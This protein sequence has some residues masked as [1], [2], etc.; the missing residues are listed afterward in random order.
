M[1]VFF[2][3]AISFPFLFI[4]GF[5]KFTLTRPVKFY[6]ILTHWK[7]NKL[8][9]MLSPSQSRSLCVSLLI[10]LIPQKMPL[11]VTVRHFLPAMIFFHKTLDLCSYVVY[12]I[13]WGVFCIFYIATLLTK[14]ARLMRQ[15]VCNDTI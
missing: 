11:K 4:W 15:T 7:L 12:W 2:L 14:W 10:I 5:F 1:H 6:C 3:C 13:L 9:L 8:P